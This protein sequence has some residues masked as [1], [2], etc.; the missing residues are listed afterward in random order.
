MA[1]A[2]AKPIR[3]L[4]LHVSPPAG[5]TPIVLTLLR[6]L[7]RRLEPS[8]RLQTLVDPEVDL[9]EVRRIAGA[10]AGSR[11]RVRFASVDFGTIFARDNAMGARDSRGR[12]VLIVPRALRTAEES[13]IEPL[14]VRATER[15]LDV[16]VERS[17]LY[18]HGGNILFD[19]ETLAIG[20]DTIAENVTRLGLTRDQVIAT[21]TAE[22]GHEVTV[23]GDAAA[24][25]F[26]NDRN[27]MTSTGQSSYHVDLDVALLGRTSAHG[28]SAVVADPDAGLAMLPAMLSRAALAGPPYLRSARARAFIADEYRAMARLSRPVLAAYCETLARRGYRVTRVPQLQTRG[29]LDGPAALPGQN[30]VYCNVLPGLNRGRPAVYY[31]PWGIPRLDALAARS[32]AEAGV[33]PVPIAR[34]AYAAWAMMDRAAGLRCFCGTLP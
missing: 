11:R 20:A 6:D 14:D 2:A 24:G 16:R 33:R 9:G 3:A 10:V 5:N 1:E 31:T 8:V 32:F 29:V 17:R 7:E 13:G 26:D 28:P 19:G 23:L 12:P 22:L 34:T 4:R 18:W 27:R 15:R 21:L 25:R 30:I